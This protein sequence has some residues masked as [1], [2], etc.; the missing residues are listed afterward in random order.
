MQ[1]GEERHSVQHAWGDNN[2]FSGRPADVS[3]TGN[4]GGILSLPVEAGKLQPDIL[5]LRPS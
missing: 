2:S 4:C 5:T 1:G 3:G